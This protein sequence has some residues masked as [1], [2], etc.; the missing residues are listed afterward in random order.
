MKAALRDCLYFVSIGGLIGFVVLL[1]SCQTTPTHPQANVSKPSPLLAW[2]RSVEN[3]FL[4]LAD[5]QRYLIKSFTIFEMQQSVNGTVTE[6]F[7]KFENN[8]IVGI[9]STAQAGVTK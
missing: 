8:Q 9:P 7:L 5:L 6:S 2:D 1:C 3:F 4:P